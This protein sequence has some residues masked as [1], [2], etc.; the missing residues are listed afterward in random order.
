MALFA[1]AMERVS[2]LIVATIPLAMAHQ[3]VTV[4]CAPTEMGDVSPRTI[5]FVNRTSILEF[6]AKCQYVM[7][8]LQTSARHVLLTAHATITTNVIVRP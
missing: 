6:S 5:A 4:Q 8:C 7:E 1:E 3:R 2:L